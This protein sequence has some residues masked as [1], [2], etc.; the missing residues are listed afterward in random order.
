MN[1][2][3]KEGIDLNIYRQTYNK[4]NI[5]YKNILCDEKE[6]KE[7]PC[8]N[9]PKNCLIETESKTN[10]IWQMYQDYAYKALDN[11]PCNNVPATNDCYENSCNNHKCP[12]DNCNDEIVPCPQDCNSNKPIQICDANQVLM[13]LDRM[14]QM[15]KE[16]YLCNQELCKSLVNYCCKYLNE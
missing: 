10:D 4:N 12:K 2:G 13:Q 3:Q 16:I 9:K 5:I 8:T 6:K 1:Q 11:L 15:L 14:E 7:V